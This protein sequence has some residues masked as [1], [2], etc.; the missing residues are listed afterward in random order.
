M[1]LQVFSTY[2]QLAQD[3]LFDLLVCVSP[4]HTTGLITAMSE[5]DEIYLYCSECNYKMT[6]GLN[7]YDKL[8]NIL[9]GH[10]EMSSQK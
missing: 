6:P 1:K 9:K 3:G 5:N 7:M 4:E 8:Y 10:E 2:Q